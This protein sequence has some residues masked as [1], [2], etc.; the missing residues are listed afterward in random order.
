MRTRI[1]FLVLLLS[2]ALAAAAVAQPASG[3]FVS[4]QLSLDIGGAYGFW[5]KGGGFDNGP[6]I[7]VA[8]SNAEFT[9]EM[10]DRWYDRASAIHDLFVDDEVKVVYFEFTA[11]GKYQGYSYYFASGDGCGYCFDSKVKSTVRASGGR[12]QGEISSAPGDKSVTFEVDFN[13]AIPDKTWGEP[14]P[15][16][17]GEQAKAYAAYRKALAAGDVSALKAITDT[18]FKQR[19][20]QHETDGDITDYVEYRWDEVHMRQ[21]TTKIVGG[22]VRGDHA[23]LLVDA[24]SKLFD[25]L[26]GD[27]ILTREGGVW[28]VSDELFQIGKR[29]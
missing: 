8:V 17:G 16:G 10:F 28:L 7:K 21:T 15:A 22:F 4:K 2:S 11:D 5:D 24:S 6:I 1:C 14:L 25:N 12:L 20:A 26:Y 19:L 3:K 18:R 13:V 29:D 23:V 9:A 27:V